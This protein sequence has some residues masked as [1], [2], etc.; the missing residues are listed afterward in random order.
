MAPE[1]TETVVEQP[2]GGS[3]TTEPQKPAGTS[4]VTPPSAPVAGT[5]PEKTRDYDREIAGFKADLAKER[6]ARQQYDTDLK[7][8][9]AELATEKQRLQLAMGI[10]PKSQGET[11]EEEVRQRFAALYPDIASLTKDDVQALREMRKTNSSLQETTNH[12]WSQ[13]GRQM[14]GSVVDA[15][16]KELGGDLSDRQKQRIATAY[17]QEANA[18]EDFLA[19][20]EQGDKTLISEFAKQWIE[21]WVEP[22]R[23][24]AVKQETQRYRPVPSGRDR[25]LVTHGDKKIDVTD[26]KAVEDLLVKSYREKNG[27]FSGRR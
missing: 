7:A 19:R 17:A 24:Q 25:N 21:D 20:H 9:R 6:K 18:N 14:V 16:A 22:A 1:G 23:R 27:E 8:A 3:T 13:H 15:V 26:N 2:G 4:Q 11:E 12:Y 5:P 10:T